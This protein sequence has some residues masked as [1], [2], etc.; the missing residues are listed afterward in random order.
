MIPLLGIGP[1]VKELTLTFGGTRG[2]GNEITLL[3]RSVLEILAELSSGVDVPKRDVTEGRASRVPRS[4]GGRQLHIHSDDEPPPD[5]YIASRYRN[6]WF[7]VDDRDLD[8][9]RVFTFL[10]VFSSIAETGTVPQVPIITIP[11]N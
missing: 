11:A 6:H 1:D 9:K 10:M 8:S 3:T 4:D 7:W 2:R 5:A